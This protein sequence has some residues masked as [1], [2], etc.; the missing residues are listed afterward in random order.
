MA[1]KY[2][3]SYIDKTVEVAPKFEKINHMIDY[4]QFNKKKLN[5][6]N[7]NIKF[8]SVSCMFFIVLILSVL[9]IN[10][11]DDQNLPN[12]N[13]DLPNDNP[14]LP[15]LPVSGIINESNPDL[16]L[17]S[18][19]YKITTSE[20]SCLYD[21]EFKIFVELST[22]AEAIVEIGDGDLFIRISDSEYYE[23]I[24]DKEIVVK[25][26]N[27][28]EYRKTDD[29]PYPIR[30]E[31]TIKPIKPSFI[32]DDICISMK[33]TLINNKEFYEM[34]FSYPFEQC[35]FNFNNEYFFN[36][37]A[38]LFVNDAEGMKLSTNYFDMIE[39]TLNKEYENG[40]IDKE[41][42]MSRYTAST[43]IYGI[44]VWV[45]DDHVGYWSLDLKVYITF[46][47]KDDE[48]KLLINKLIYEYDAERNLKEAANLILEIAYKF[49]DI[50]Q[51]VYE[52]EML[53]IEEN[54]VLTGRYTADHLIPFDDYEDY[55]HNDYEYI[56]N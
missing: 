40:I 56:I 1:K 11:F 34:Y 54:S 7:I 8:V 48:T 9:I 39:N 18:I 12:D 5:P 45:N 10:K 25:N 13:P 31:F 21:Q 36:I 29:N 28:K 46:K 27:S 6:F 37:R 44:C 26:F 19:G 50:T 47:N 4:E 24:G 38:M 2:I 16:G 41:T 15:T 52:R 35:W 49:G 20:T 53:S 23:I 55:I 33:Y 22:S 51:E 32:V 17:T 14:D 43:L 42:Y 3:E 30:V